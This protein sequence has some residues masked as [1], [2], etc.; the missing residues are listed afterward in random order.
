M[1]RQDMIG[2]LPSPTTITPFLE[3]QLMIN[4]NMSDQYVK[5]IPLVASNQYPMP[6]A[7]LQPLIQQIPTPASSN[8][9]VPPTAT[10]APVPAPTNILSKASSTTASA[11]AN[12]P[13]NAPATGKKNKYPCPY[14]QSHNCIAT[15]TTSGHAA[16]HGKKHTGEKGVHCPICN[17]AFTRKDNMKQ[18]ERTHKNSGSGSS[19]ETARRSKAAI[20]KA[21]QKNKQ[22]KKSDSS[23][24]D[25]SRRSSMMRSPLSEVTSLAP[26]A[27]DTP[28]NGEETTFYTDPPQMLMPGMQIPTMP[29]SVSPNSL[30]PPLSEEL[31]MGPG[32]LVPQP[33]YDTKADLGMNNGTL[34]MPPA[35]I[36]GFSDLDTLAQAAESFDPYYQQN[37]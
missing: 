28:L 34:A 23:G 29:D 4:P 17:K 26:S 33:L 31:L 8:N 15:F 36:R 13:A 7:S 27:I 1:L 12:A 19:D 16:R 2:Y 30:Y 18:H 32:G 22:V 14:A 10:S 3:Q 6:P 24:S 21:A 20:T 5:N 25:P 37:M 9:S 35:L 11:P